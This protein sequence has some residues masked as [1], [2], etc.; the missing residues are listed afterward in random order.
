[1]SETGNAAGYSGVDFYAHVTR[2]GGPLAGTIM[3]VSRTVKNGTWMAAI[4]IPVGAVAG[5]DALP[6]VT[7]TSPE[8]LA[9]RAV[10]VSEARA[11]D[12]AP[13]MMRFVDAHHRSP[14]F[15]AMYAVELRKPNATKGL[16]PISAQG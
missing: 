14:E 4:S 16:R 10:K 8:W 12:I 5:K 1:M 7:W 6:V 15:R 9:R 11:R 13:D 2:K 3:V